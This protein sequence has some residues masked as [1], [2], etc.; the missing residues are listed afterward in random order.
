MLF[1]SACNCFENALFEQLLVHCVID[2]G[3]VTELLWLEQ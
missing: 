3:I 1:S 2:P